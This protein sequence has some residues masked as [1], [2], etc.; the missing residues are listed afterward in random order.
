[1]PDLFPITNLEQLGRLVREVRKSQGLRQDEVGRLSHTFIGE[2]EMGKRTAQIG[3][4]F[5]ALR[6]L[7]IR[8]H[9]EVAADKKRSTK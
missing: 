9:V 3:K 7:G 1:M 5:D 6:E 4:V 2:L 8:L